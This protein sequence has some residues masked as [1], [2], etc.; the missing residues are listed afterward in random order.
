MISERGG[1]DSS[2]YIPSGFYGGKPDQ[3]TQL[4]VRL[5]C[6][7]YRSYSRYKNGEFWH[8]LRETLTMT[9]WK[10]NERLCLVSPAPRDRSTAKPESTVVCIGLELVIWFVKDFIGDAVAFSLV[11]L[12]LGPMYPIM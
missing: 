1:D 5:D 7:P 12:F 4:T 9:A 6:W 10:S 8:P 2:G 3:T 11:G